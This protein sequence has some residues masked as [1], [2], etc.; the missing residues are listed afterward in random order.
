[1]VF[2]DIAFLNASSQQTF[3][4][5]HPTSFNSSAVSKKLLKKSVFFNKYSQSLLDVTKDGIH[6]ICF[7]NND[8]EFYQNHF[9]FASAGLVHIK[10]SF[11]YPTQAFIKSPRANLLL[12]NELHSVSRGDFIFMRILNMLKLLRRILITS[13]LISRFGV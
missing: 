10:D 3:S 12:I 7:L 8:L 2:T 9:R 1:M 4:K 5:S 13:L 11:Y 6:G